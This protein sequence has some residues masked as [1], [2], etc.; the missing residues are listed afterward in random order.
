MLSLKTDVI[1]NDKQLSD[2]FLA[3][4]NDNNSQ[5][6]FYT[7]LLNQFSSEIHNPDKL[8]D[9]VQDLEEN[10]FS[11]DMQTRKIEFFKLTNALSKIYQNIRQQESKELKERYYEV[12]LSAYEYVGNNKTKFNKNNRLSS[13]L[14]K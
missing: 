6:N 10:N 4:F 11:N 9:L 7:N 2:S 1:L 8:N 14:Y 5:P 12:P 3:Y 13:L